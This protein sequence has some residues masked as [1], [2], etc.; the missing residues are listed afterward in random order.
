MDD[1]LLG[2]IPIHPESN[3]AF[4]PLWCFVLGGPMI[5]L[6]AWLDRKGYSPTIPTKIAGAFMLST[7]AFGLLGLSAGSIGENG[8]ISADWI[9][10]VHFF[11]NRVLSLLLGLWGLGLFLKWCH[12]TL[13]RFQSVYVRLLFH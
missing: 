4:N 5:Q 2:F 1:T 3:M 12:V 11:S 6:Y 9:L 10:L 8:K 7:I 13:R